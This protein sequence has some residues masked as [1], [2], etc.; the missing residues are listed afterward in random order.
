MLE[1]FFSVKICLHKLNSVSCNKLKQ[2]L[3]ILWHK[4]PWKLSVSF[5]C[6][7]R[8]N[9]RSVENSAAAMH[10][11][12]P[13]SFQITHSHGSARVLY[14]GDDASQWENGKFD[15]LPPPNPL[16]DHH[17]KLNTWLRHGY[18]SMCKIYSQSLQGFLFPICAKLRINMFT[19]LL[20]SPDTSNSLQPRP[21]N[22][23][24]RVIR[25][26]TRFRARMCLFGVRRQN[27]NI[28]TP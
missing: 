24:S 11:S 17:K 15:P 28:Y 27:F 2:S 26:T 5:W 20:F 12:L 16:T 10:F 6:P 4:T 3:Y 21:L 7:I 1:M 13:F 14:K 25:Q 23:F 18:L 9:I 8:K 19:R 22:R